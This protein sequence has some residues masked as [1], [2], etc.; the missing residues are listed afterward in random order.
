L[1]YGEIATRALIAQDD[2]TESVLDAD[3]GHEAHHEPERE[4]HHGEVVAVDSGDDGRTKALDA[5]GASL[6][7]RLSGGDVARDVSVGQHA[8]GHVDRFDVRHDEGVAHDGNRREHDMPASGEPPQHDARLGLVARLAE[9]VAVHHHDRVGRDD[10][11][12][13]LPRGD[14]GGFPSGQA[15]RVRARLLRGERGLVDVRG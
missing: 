2:L 10:H 4:T 14:D 6:V 8:K 11:G 1:P 3:A 7:H 12:V 13:R 9:D 15:L 5:I